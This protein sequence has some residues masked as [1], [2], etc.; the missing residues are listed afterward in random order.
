MGEKERRQNVGQSSAYEGGA[1]NRPL[2]NTGEFCL[3]VPHY[4]TVQSLQD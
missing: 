3:L 4:I 1:L 2:E